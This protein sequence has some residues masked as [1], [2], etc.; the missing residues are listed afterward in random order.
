MSL[1]IPM[2]LFTMYL[3]CEIDM[4]LIVLSAIAGGIGGLVGTYDVGL[5]YGVWRLG[6]TGIWIA[7]VSVVVETSRGVVK[8]DGRSLHS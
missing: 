8:R 3:Q 6:W 1:K 7:G 2:S 5:V 4:P